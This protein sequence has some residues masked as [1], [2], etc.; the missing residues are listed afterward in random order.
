MKLLN[1]LRLVFSH[2]PE[3][4]QVLE[5][6]RE[7]EEKRQ[8][9]LRAEFVDLCAKHQPR[10]PGSYFSEEACDVCRL[11]DWNERLALHAAILSAEIRGEIENDHANESWRS[12]PDRVRY[13]IEQQERKIKCLDR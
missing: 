12:L 6:K 9:K 11:L 2:G 10:Q 5:E 13:L 4:D 1:R 3:I 7:E 8:R